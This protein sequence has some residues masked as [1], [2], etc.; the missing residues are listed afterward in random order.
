MITKY[1]AQVWANMYY[2]KMN[3]L[4]DI[5]LGVLHQAT[6]GQ[7]SYKYPCPDMY[8]RAMT[9]SLTRDDLKILQKLVELGYE[10]KWEDGGLLVIFG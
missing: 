4:H 3:E 9:Q 2:N 5:E 1:T 10:T 8:R 6:I 7:F